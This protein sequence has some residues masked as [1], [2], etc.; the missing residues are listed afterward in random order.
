VNDYVFVSNS[1]TNIVEFKAIL[2]QEFH[3]IDENQLLMT[4][5]IKLFVIEQKGGYFWT[6]QNTFI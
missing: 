1:L 2:L 5:V 4:L 6:N 3:M